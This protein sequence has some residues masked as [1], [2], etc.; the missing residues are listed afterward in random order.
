MKNYVSF[1]LLLLCVT[2]FVTAQESEGSKISVT[3]EGII[4]TVPDQVHLYFAVQN[5][6][7][8]PLEVKQRNDEL[9]GKLIELL[10]ENG[11]DGKDLQT[12]RL[13]LR[14][15]YN[16]R[17]EDSEKYMAT[18]SFSLLIRDLK[19][20]DEINIL[21]LSAGVNQIEQVVFSSTRYEEL[22]NRAREKAVKDALG[23][24][25]L[26]GASLG[27][28]PGKL[29]NMEEVD[30]GGAMPVFREAVADYSGGNR[31]QIAPG[32]IIISNK[33]HLT[34]SLQ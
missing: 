10:K 30:T 3:G 18:Q 5:E 12:Q 2:P 34:Y 21:L 23:K 1:L 33:I 14:K 22:K 19:S 25:A 20:Y 15:Q 24:V 29:I 8:D 13:N 7:E 32:E 26:Y 6:G 9:T 31:S 27:M 16:N 11:V 28:S 17:T 4:R